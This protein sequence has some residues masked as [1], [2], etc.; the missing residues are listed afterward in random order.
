MKDIKKPENSEI[1][2]AEENSEN[3]G[4]DTEKITELTNDLQRLRADFENYRKQTEFQKNQA[5]NITK[6]ATV[7]KFLPLLDDINRAISTYPEQLE[8]L[9]KSLQKTLDNLSLKK[10]EAETDM[11]FNPELHEAVMTEESD[12]EKDVIAEVLRDGYYYMDEVVRP[13]M[14]KS[15]KI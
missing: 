9:A 12:G 6:A 8:P 14:V 3:R 11:E 13:T 4:G 2:S 7:I 15:K 1:L 10:I 5:M